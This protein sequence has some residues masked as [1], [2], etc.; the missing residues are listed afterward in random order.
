[1]ASDSIEGDHGYE[2]ETVFGY[3]NLGNATGNWLM[4]AAIARQIFGF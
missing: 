2:W 3:G 1:M 4:P